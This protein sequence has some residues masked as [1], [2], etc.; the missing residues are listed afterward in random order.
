MRFLIAG[1]GFIDQVGMAYSTDGEPDGV[2][3]T[4]E[5]TPIGG[6]WWEWAQLFN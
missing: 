6:G 3:G 2:D 1:S 5:Y 4:D